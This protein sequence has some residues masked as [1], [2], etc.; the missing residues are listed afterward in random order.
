MV[1]AL[2]YNVWPHMSFWAG[3]SPTLVYRWRPNGLDP[4]S[5]I[6]DVIILK[7]V[8]KNGPRPAPAPAHELGIDDPWSDAPELGGLVGIFE[9]DM[10][11]LPYVQDGLHASATGEVHF[12]RYSELRIRKLHQMIDQY[13]AAAD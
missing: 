9:Q 6:M 8:P 5:S 3:Y 11:N 12:G 13:L 10:G 4:E 2:L 1:D 7:R